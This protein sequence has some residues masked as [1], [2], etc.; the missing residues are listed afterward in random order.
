MVYLVQTAGYK[1]V[2]IPEYFDK[3]FILGGWSSNIPLF[4]AKM[5]EIYQNK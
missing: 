3:T 4:A 5:S 2:L 1:D